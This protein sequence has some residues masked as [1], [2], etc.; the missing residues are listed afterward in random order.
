MRIPP[1]IER[2]GNPGVLHE[3]AARSVA[4]WSRT[5]ATPTADSVIRLPRPMFFASLAIVVENPADCA[6]MVGLDLRAV[7]AAEIARLVAFSNGTMPQTQI[8]FARGLAGAVRREL[9]VINFDDGFANSIALAAHSTA[10]STVTFH[11]SVYVGV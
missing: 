8:I 7:S 2:P 1:I 9:P 5:I 11:G 10:V 3:G 6:F 4:P